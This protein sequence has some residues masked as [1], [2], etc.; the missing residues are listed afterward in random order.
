MD[1]A[2]TLA[3]KIKVLESKS[4]CVGF[5]IY[6]LR[7]YFL[8]LWNYCF[9]LL[10]VTSSPMFFSLVIF[11]FNEKKKVQISNGRKQILAIMNFHT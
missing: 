6:W 4:F 5:V 2:D 7:C 10:K 11:H 1:W 9:K 8:S 3:Y